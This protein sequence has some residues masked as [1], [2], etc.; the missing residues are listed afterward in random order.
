MKIL[1]FDD[2]QFCHV[3]SSKEKTYKNQDLWSAQTKYAHQVVDEIHY[4]RDN[5]RHQSAKTLREHQEAVQS[6]R[7]TA[8]A[9]PYNHCKLD[10]PEDP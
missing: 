4:I 3:D 2:I 9:V 1:L 8:A 10:S 7:P 6:K 5:K